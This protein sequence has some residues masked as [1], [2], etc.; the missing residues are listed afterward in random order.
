MMGVY[1][2]QF[3][4]EFVKFSH[5]TD[6]GMRRLYLTVFHWIYVIT[7][8]QRTQNGMRRPCLTVLYGIDIIDFRGQKNEE[9]IFDFSAQNLCHLKSERGRWGLRLA[10]F[11]GNDFSGHT[12]GSHQAALPPGVSDSHLHQHCGRGDGGVA[13]QAALA[14]CVES[15]HQWLHHLQGAQHHR[16][17]ATQVSCTF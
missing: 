10:I 7:W 17:A 1:V 5:V 8:S 4:M 11:C 2:W 16:S 3:S 9:M 6:S 13:T 12:W 14:G 15:S